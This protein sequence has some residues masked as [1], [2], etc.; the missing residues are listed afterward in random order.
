LAG[1]T[2]A[3]QQST[4]DTLFP[5]TGGTDHIAYSTNGSS[6]AAIIARTPIGATGWAAATAATPSVKANA[7]AL[8]SAAASGG[9][10][11]THFA[12]YTALTAG[13]QRTDWTALT[14][15]KAVTTGDQLTWAVGACAVTL[16]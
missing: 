7:N 9:G 4:L 12:I 8:T 15:S 1:L 2:Q 5:T 10:T 6:E 16:D 3:L 11:V 13:T 14:A